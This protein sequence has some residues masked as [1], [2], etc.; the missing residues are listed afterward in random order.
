MVTIPGGMP[1]R[2]R[3]PT[4]PAGEA[5]DAGCPH[6]SRSGSPLVQTGIPG[7]P[8]APGRCVD[9][10]WIVVLDIERLRQAR[11]KAALSQERRAHEVMVSM[12]ARPCPAAISAR[13]PASPPRSDSTPRRSPPRRMA[14]GRTPGWMRSRPPRPVLWHQGQ[15]RHAPGRSRP[16]PIRSG[17]PERSLPGEER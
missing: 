5:A 14:S 8:Q 15:A 6:R 3:C 10:Y 1:D 12:S 17:R 16:P 9:R 4:A 2:T 13:T 11:E 7:V